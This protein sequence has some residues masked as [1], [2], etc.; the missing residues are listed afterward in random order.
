MCNGFGGIY[1][2][3]LGFFFSEPNKNGDCSHST[4]I[5]RMGLKENNSAYL[6]SFVRIE[7]ADWTETSFRFDEEETLPGWLDQE[8]AREIAIKLI[9]RVAPTY[10]EYHKIA[11]QAWAEYRKIKDQA[12][13]EYRKIKDQAEAEFLS[14]ISK[15]DGYVCEV[16]EP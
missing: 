10:A 13:A 15:I 5:K 2:K 3:D 8:E 1:V 11:D 12:W 4:I 14:T 6:R 7:F 16:T 9:L